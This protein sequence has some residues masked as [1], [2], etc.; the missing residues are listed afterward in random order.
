MGSRSRRPVAYLSPQPGA[1][2]GP[3]GARRPAHFH[4]KRFNPACFQR[5]RAR[6]LA[7]EAAASTS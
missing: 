1:C 6:V 7:A 2:L 4:L 5:L 3:E